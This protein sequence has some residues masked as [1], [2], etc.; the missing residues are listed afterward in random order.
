MP[1]HRHLPMRFASFHLHCCAAT[2]K[3]KSNQ[4]P[5]MGHARAGTSYPHP[6]IL[7]TAHCALP[8]HTSCAA[9]LHRSTCKHETVVAARSPLKGFTVFL[10]LWLPCDLCSHVLRRLANHPTLNKPPDLDQ[11]RNVAR[12]AR[13]SWPMGRQCWIPAKMMDGPA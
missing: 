8:L 12:S 13:G 4:T 6:A 1:A 7:Q 3:N 10:F 2:K 9:R 11:M 5:V